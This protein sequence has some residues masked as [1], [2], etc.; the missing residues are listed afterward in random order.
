[1]AAAVVVVVVVVVVVGWAVLARRPSRGGA[2]RQ[3]WGGPRTATGGRSILT[4]SLCRCP[5]LAS[6]RQTWGGPRTATGGRS[7]LT[8]SL[9]SC[10]HL[11][12]LCLSSGWQLRAMA[13]AVAESDARDAPPAGWGELGL[14]EE[15]LAAVRTTNLSVP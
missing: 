12:T 6:C 1:V 2:C 14:A 13:P 5:S 7:I 10:R 8:P 15:L 9:A 11:L 4:P 3:T